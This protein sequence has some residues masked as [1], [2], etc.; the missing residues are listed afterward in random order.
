MAEDQLT[1]S[2]V[3]MIGGSAG[4]LDV[5]LYILPKLRPDLAVVIVIVLH[6]KTNVESP[7]INLLQT[8]TTLPVSEAEE[9]EPLVPGHI[10]LAPADYHL[11]LERNKTFSLDY[12]EKVHFSRPSID[13]S[14][15]TA[16]DV[17]SG[18]VTGILLSGANAD[19]VEGLR[20]ISERG[21]DVIIQEPSTA[22]VAFMPAEA[23]RSGIAA[24]VFTPEQMMHYI[25]SLK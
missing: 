13:V 2:R 7:L 24:K 22:D 4:S 11:L 23:I 8:K 19:G 6:R 3:V 14:F 21:G 5:L 25:N 16:A 1:P 18:N 10:Y 9:K 12:S 20:R 17:F 15:E